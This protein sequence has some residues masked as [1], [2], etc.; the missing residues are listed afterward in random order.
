MKLHLDI[1]AFFVS[2]ERA[3]KKELLAKPVVVASNDDHLLFGKKSKNQLVLAK[4][5]EAKAYGIKTAMLLSEAKRLCPSLICVSSDLSFYK[6]KSKE[7][8][9]YLDSVF[10]ELEPFSID[11]F[12]ASLDGLVAKDEILDFAYKLQSDVKAS[13]DLPISIG[14]SDS[15]WGAKFL[16]T[17]AKPYGVL[18]LRKEELLTNFADERLISF[19]GLGEK[20]LK[21]LFLDGVHKIGDV[22]DNKNAFLKLGKNGL[23]SYK[24]ILGIDNEAIVN[25]ERK[26][27]GIG[28][29]FEPLLDEK[30]LK[31]RLRILNRHLCY[32]FLAYD[33]RPSNYTISLT[34]SDKTSFSKSLNSYYDFNEELSLKIFSKLLKLGLRDK[35]IINIQLRLSSFDKGQN[36]GLFKD[37]K[38][39]LYKSLQ[40]LRDKYGVNIIKKAVES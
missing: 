13:F 23:K 11:E 24:R 36:L 35:K 39:A 17:M 7:L 16:T 32:D 4:S 2:A 26:S 19:P 31:R 9:S 34:Y 28:R 30:E 12:F 33:L 14:I 25:K 37:D 27:F 40:K 20:S 8:K 5:Y 15:K 29:S 3:R 18:F 21:S 10:A 6:R 1:D 22:K 38:E